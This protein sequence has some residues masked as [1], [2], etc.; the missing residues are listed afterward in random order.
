MVVA[1]LRGQPLNGELRAWQTRYGRTCTTA[2]LY[3]LYALLGG[4]T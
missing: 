3:R 1:H 4:E 2:P